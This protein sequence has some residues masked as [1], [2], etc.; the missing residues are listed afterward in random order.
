M[1]RRSP[2]IPRDG[3]GLGLRPV[4]YRAIAERPPDVDFFEI[5]VENY[6]GPSELPRRR[7]AEVAARYPLVAHGVSLDL[8]G[9]SP[10][11][12]AHLAAVRGLLEAHRIPWFTDHLCWTRSGGASHHDLLP[13]PYAE[14]LVAYAAERARRVQE[15]LGVPF[16][17][18]NLSSYVAW[19]RDEMPEWVFYRR[20]VAEAGCGY[21][22]D[23]NNI[24]VSSVNH[25]FD[26]LTYL[27]A[28]DWDRVLQVHVAG[29]T[30][31]PSGMRLDTHDQAVCD[32]VW[33]LYRAAWRMGG[34]FP[35]LLEWDD[36]IPS[37]EVAVAEVH[38]A[39]EARG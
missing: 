1:D 33:A 15:A 38:R 11:D 30:I 12:E 3:V 22:L 6:L 16:A 35:T 27:E 25:G 20:V 34:P 19:A 13:A 37:L 24:Y 5:I 32:E 10:L 2:D 9:A 18:E 7:L 36:A 39:R 17:I 4:H 31:L 29:H 28:I 23:L 21:L 8:L 26:P 14:A